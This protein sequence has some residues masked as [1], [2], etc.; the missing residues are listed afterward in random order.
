MNGLERTFF[1]VCAAAAARIAKRRKRSADKWLGR[2]ER[3]SRR[4]RPAPLP[5]IGD[6]Q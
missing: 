2:A 5:T 3:W 4:A 6:R 1:A